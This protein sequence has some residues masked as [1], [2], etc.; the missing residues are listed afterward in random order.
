MKERLVLNPQYVL[1]GWKKLPYA[2]YN[3][4]RNKAVFLNKE[5]FDLILQCSGKQEIDDEILSEPLRALLNEMKE[6]HV[7]HVA[8]EGETRDLFYKFY[9]NIY[10][11][12]VHWSVTGHCNYHCRHCF[13]SAPCGELMQPTLEQ[14]KDIIR[15]FAEC[16]ISRVGITGGE[17]LVHPDFMAIVDELIANNIVINVIYSNG[18]LVTQGLLDELHERGLYPS[19]QISFDGVG[20]HDWMRGVPGAEKAALDA[21]RLLHKNGHAV[22]CSMCLCKENIGSLRETVKVLAE[23]GCSGVKTQCASPQGLWKT[24]KEHFLTYDE[25]L[26]AYLN[27]IPQFAEDGAP[28]S[29]QMEGFFTYEKSTNQYF[30][31]ADKSVSEGMDI[32]KMP[33]CGVIHSGFYLGPS[34][35]VVPCMSL[36]YIEMTGDFPNIY[37]MPLKEILS[38]SSFTEAMTKRVSHVLNHTEE[39]VDC[40]YRFK[41]CG[42]CR[43]FAAANN[44]ADYLAADKVTCKI[45]KEHWDEKLYS[46]ADK[47][48]TRKVRKTAEMEDPHTGC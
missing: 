20:Y 36:D 25:V 27:Y 42:G 17:P 34:G 6:K 15:Q 32:S 10:K 23:A 48:F 38:D 11:R 22:S 46:V 4:E 9:D 14:C 43:A 28:L 44:P 45:F 5:Q 21:I 12:D 24:Q 37:D 7:V 19:F 29:L 47:Y 16:G 31:V 30:L 41:C 3:T 26:Q 18:K 13:Q 1:K 40:E 35:N 8:E 39:C 33:L 2:I